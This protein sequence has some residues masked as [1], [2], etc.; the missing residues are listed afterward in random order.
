VEATVPKSEVSKVQIAAENA[1][2]SGDLKKVGT[3]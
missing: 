1:F 3:P 2:A